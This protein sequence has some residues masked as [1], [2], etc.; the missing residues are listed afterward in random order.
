[1]VVGLQSSHF[2]TYDFRQ[3]YND[4]G[5]I[6]KKVDVYLQHFEFTR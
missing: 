4:V 1:M 6:L 3:S 5:P 2:H